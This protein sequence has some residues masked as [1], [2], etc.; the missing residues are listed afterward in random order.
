VK[1]KQR[2]SLSG[3]SKQLPLPPEPAKQV[4]NLMK[5]PTRLKDILARKKKESAFSF[6]F[7]S[8]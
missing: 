4:K 2:G 8:V 6:S 5:E 7:T 3:M 1:T